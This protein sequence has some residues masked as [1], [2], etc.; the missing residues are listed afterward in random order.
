MR[1]IFNMLK[2]INSRIEELQEEISNQQKN[3]RGI[4]D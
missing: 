2:L 1:Y 4:K 3:K